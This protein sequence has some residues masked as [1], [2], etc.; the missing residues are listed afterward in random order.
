VDAFGPLFPGKKNIKALKYPRSAKLL[1]EN[2]FWRAYSLWYPD[3]ASQHLNQR[4]DEAASTATDA[5][6]NVAARL[7]AT[8]GQFT[9]AAATQQH[10]YENLVPS[11]AHQIDSDLMAS[12][13]VVEDF[14]EG[15]GP[16]NIEKDWMHAPSTGE[17]AG[18]GSAA[19]NPLGTDS[20]PRDSRI[21]KKDITHLC[22]NGDC[23]GRA[24]LW[25]KICKQTWYCSQRCQKLHWKVH[26]EGCKKTQDRSKAAATAKKQCSDCGCKKAKKY[27]SNRQWNTKTS[28]RCL[29]CTQYQGAADGCSGGANDY[30]VRQT[31]LNLLLRWANDGLTQ[32]SRKMENGIILHIPFGAPC[33]K[34][35]ELE[36][37]LGGWPFSTK[38]EGMSDHEKEH[39]LG[40]PFRI[41]KQAAEVFA[42]HDAAVGHAFEVCSHPDVERLLQKILADEAFV[43]RS[44][45]PGL[46]AILSNLAK[47]GEANDDNLRMIFGDA[48]YVRDL[49]LDIGVQIAEPGRGAS[50]PFVR[51]EA[52][53]QRMCSQCT[54]KIV[55]IFA[56]DRCDIAQYCSN[57]CKTLAW[58]WHCDECV[59]LDEL[60]S[61]GADVDP[62]QFYDAAAEGVSGFESGNFDAKKSWDSRGEPRRLDLPWCAV[63]IERA[64]A[65]MI[66]LDFVRSVSFEG[67]QKNPKGMQ[68]AEIQ[69]GILLRVPENGADILVM[70]TK[71]FTMNG[72]GLWEGCAWD[73]AFIVAHVDEAGEATWRSVPLPNSD[74]KR[75]AVEVNKAEL[76][77]ECCICL[78]SIHGTEEHDEN[79]EEHDGEEFYDASSGTSFEECNRCNRCKKWFHQHCLAEWFDVKSDSCPIC[80][81]NFAFERIQDWLRTARS[82][83][84]IAATQMADMPET[85]IAAGESYGPEIVITDEN[86]AEIMINDHPALEAMTEAIF[87][88]A[89]VL[90][91]KLT[92]EFFLGANSNWSQ[93]RRQAGS[94]LS[95]VAL[96]N[97]FRCCQPLFTLDLYMA[98]CCSAHVQTMFPSETLAALRRHPLKALRLGQMT[99]PSM[100]CLIQLLGAFSPSLTALALPHMH[101][102]KKCGR[103]RGG[104]QYKD[105]TLRAGSP[106]WDAISDSNIYMLD[107]SFWVF[108]PSSEAD[109]CRILPSLRSLRQ[110][111]LSGGFGDSCSDRPGLLTDVGLNSIAIYCKNLQVLNIMSNRQISHNGV[112]KVLGGCPLRELDIGCTGIDTKHLKEFCTKSAT[113]VMLVFSKNGEFRESPEDTYNVQLAVQACDGRVILNDV[114]GGVVKNKLASEHVSREIVEV[115]GDQIQRYSN[116]IRFEVNGYESLLSPEDEFK[117]SIQNVS[118]EF[119]MLQDVDELVLKFE[120]SRMSL[121]KTGHRSALATIA[122]DDV[123]SCSSEKDV[124]FRLKNGSYIHISAKHPPCERIKL[125][126][127][128]HCMF[129]VRN[130]QCGRFGCTAELARKKCSRCKQISYCSKECQHAHWSRHKIVCKNKESEAPTPEHNF[131]AKRAELVKKWSARLGYISKETLRMMIQHGSLDGGPDAITEKDLDYV[132]DW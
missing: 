104:Y 72:G 110:L 132:P 116:G 9:A 75:D 126:F 68:K 99:L 48:N 53:R 20:P 107:L 90:R 92:Q 89:K 73:G 108:D 46:R 36:N 123:L 18:A 100:D 23:P 82:Q 64:A 93:L 113:L 118:T 129:C 79:V 117:V 57:E 44:R 71:C 55:T 78:E 24:E 11:S 102:A 122:S 19:V 25:C 35:M 59:P 10:G 4:L 98:D 80:R 34:Q 26:Q 128:H 40:M 15:S 97:M 3:E 62:I 47:I 66:G 50:I 130:N 77:E 2:D 109:F 81:Y 127:L 65:G 41:Q 112:V 17:G 76:H 21:Q 22:G 37:L 101:F 84:T 69:L 83:A 45:F 49:M 85:Q 30:V 125:A 12:A 96:E 38:F 121:F 114:Y 88:S 32:H 119:A 91:L 13:E 87:S 51:V 29:M 1:S 56:C 6:Q 67:G 8:D 33:T 61:E 16:G 94:R 86:A 39:V 42:D 74:L 124:C 115:A 60:I 14:M 7:I 52:L 95:P 105:A 106:L 70:H 120:P 5:I 27:F 111:D 43:E 31:D 103:S 54:A 28:H 131:A 63:E 58:T